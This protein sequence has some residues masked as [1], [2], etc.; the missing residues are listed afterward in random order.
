[1]AQRVKDA[2][3]WNTP[4]NTTHQSQLSPSVMT[5]PLSGSLAGF[6]SAS[7]TT[8]LTAIIDWIR[9]NTIPGVIRE[10]T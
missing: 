10:Y 7:V 8:E 3:G 2:A 4:G 6:P 9:L 1:M 5:L